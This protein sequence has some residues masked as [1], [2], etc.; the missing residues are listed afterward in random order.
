VHFVYDEQLIAVF[1]LKIDVNSL[2]GGKGKAVFTKIT[3]NYFSFLKIPRLLFLPTGHG[4]ENVHK[5]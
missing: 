2:L 1:K 5:H 4:T 3:N